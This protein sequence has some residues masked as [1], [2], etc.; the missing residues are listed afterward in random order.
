MLRHLLEAPHGNAQQLAIDRHAAEDFDRGG[1]PVVRRDCPVNRSATPLSNQILQL[2]T[3]NLRQT[4]GSFPLII[5]S[6]DG[7]ITPQ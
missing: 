1:S 6:E 2:K 3:C 5:F 4:H 7:A